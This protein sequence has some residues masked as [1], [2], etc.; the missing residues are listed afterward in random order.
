LVL[1][2]PSGQYEAVMF[3]E[4]LNRF[5]DVLEPGK[6]VI[7]LV[8]A[9]MRPEGVSVRVQSVEEIDT[10]KEKSSTNVRVFVRDDAPTKSIKPLLTSRGDGQMSFVVV[11]NN[12]ESE[13]E[14]MLKERYLLSKQM[15][16][17]MKAIPGVVDV[18]VY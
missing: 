15:A 16:N 12:G 18:Q 4:A 2:D 5:S 11:Q 14:V 10:S 3:E 9:D 6:S 17:A 1:S 7:L 8:G 13:V